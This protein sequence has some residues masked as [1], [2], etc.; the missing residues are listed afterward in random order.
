MHDCSDKSLILPS[1]LGVKAADLPV[2]L[3]ICRKS[4][5]P[6]GD[7]P[8]LQHQL[9]LAARS[10]IK[11]ITIFA[12]Y[13]A[14]QIAEFAGNGSR[15]GIAVRVQV[16]DRPS[17]TAGAVVRSLDLLPEHF[18][19][20]YGDLMLAVD[21][22]RMGERHLSQNADFTA[23]VHPNDHPHDSDLVSTDAG[24]WITSLHASPHPPDQY[25]ANLVN[26]ALYVARRDALRPWAATTGEVDFVK[27]VMS[28]LLT[29]GARV[30]AFRS[31]EYI[32]DV[33]TPARLEKVKADWNAGRIN[34]EN[35]NRRR[36]AVFFDRDGTLNCEKGGLRSPEQLELVAGAGPALRSLRE[37]G[38]L[39]VVLT[40]QPVI[41]RG[42]ASEADVAAIHRRLEWELGKQGAYLD[43]IYFCPHHPD[44][45]FAGE[46]PD[47]K[48]HCECRK[49]GQGLFE[50]ACRDLDID[51]PGSWMIGDQTR[52]IETARRAGLHSILVRTGMA[53]RDGRFP[54]AP[55]HIADDLAGAADF[56]LQRTNIAAI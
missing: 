23:L 20:L 11:E 46:R 16:E 6:V 1:S 52:D 49:P 28:G 31:N 13:L 43:A 34:I 15:F 54:C 38:F 50:Q 51:P 30:L 18:F 37:A 14:D 55:D 8:L 21:L 35:S 56:I 26:A 33:G 19:V 47:L 27:H 36:P 5:I 44:S 42:E 10:G 25:H 41:A 3:A 39:L 22:Q 29:K 48:I 40:N 12:G 17:G 4:L 53:G 7:K 24:D 9:E 32:K 45:G 2:C